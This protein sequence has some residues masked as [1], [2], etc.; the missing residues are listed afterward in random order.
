MSDQHEL[1]AS[2]G[3]PLYRQI[4]EILRREIISGMAS[5]DR[6][7]TEAKLLERFGV[8][9]A[10][11]RQALG[12]LADEGYV[13]RKQGRGTFPVESP[14][15]HRPAGVRAGGLQKF[16]TSQGLKT[17]SRVRNYGRVEAPSR[18][19][20][21]FALANG[22]ELLH[23]DRLILVDDEPMALATMY[24]L[25]PVTFAPSA[26]ELEAAGT[27]FE[28]LE[29]SH[30]IRLE[31]AEHEAWATTASA[32]QASDLGVGEGE[33]L[34]ALETMF[35]TTGGIAAGHR[36]ALHRADDFRY[37]FAENY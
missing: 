32:S 2:S 16:L 14:Q 29:H 33:A 20:A 11:I 37:R 13:Y 12:E 36:L 24:M 31:S 34:F 27:A 10:P 23:F 17:T 18:I 22:P 7:L 8:S 26:E 9:R 5:P 25:A 15:I 30:G 28:L 6:P 19:R 1:S 4:K 3:T 35:Y 21:R